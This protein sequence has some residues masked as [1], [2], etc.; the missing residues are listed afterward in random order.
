MIHFIAEKYNHINVGYELQKRRCETFFLVM[1]ALQLGSVCFKAV[2]HG[3]QDGTR[4]H[5]HESMHSH[6][7]KHY[8]NTNISRTDT[9]S[10]N[11]TVKI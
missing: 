9:S 11:S 10:K 5:L 2:C 1:K 7:C 8:C 6:L 3:C 4:S